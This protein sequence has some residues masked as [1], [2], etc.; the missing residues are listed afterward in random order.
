M[1]MLLTGDP[2]TAQRAY[3]IGMVNEVVPGDRLIAA[4]QALAEGIAANAPLSVRAAKAMVSLT[5]EL[6]L[7]TAYAEAERMW[8][9]VYLSEDAQEGPRAFLREAHTDLEG[10]L[11]TADLPALVA[12]LSAETDDLLR[13]LAYLDDNDNLDDHDKAWLT[14]T[15]ARGWDIKDQVSHLAYFDETTT[16]SALDPERF[17]VEAAELTGHG[18]DFA[19]YIAALH[20]ERTGRDLL[21]WF[22]QARRSLLQ[23]FSGLDPT[24][25]LPWYSLPMGPASSVTARLME[26]WAH[27][28]DIA[29]ALWVTRAPTERLRH[30]AHL[31]VSTIGWSFVVGGLEPPSVPVHVALTAPGGG[32]WTWGPPDATERIEGPALDFCLLVTQRRHRSELAVTATG[33]TANRY[34]G[35]AQVYAGPPGPGRQ[36]VH[37]ATT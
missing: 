12:D 26:T 20:H 2:I 35:L 17:K 23:T 27:G 19:D 30:I 5:A 21:A 13:L 34:L 16:L 18:D 4:T 28:Q 24:V 15:P 3:E 31:G 14:P 22:T 1:Q 9:P 10:M 6:P 7:A 32:S 36:P 37:E 11:M 8:E 29:D 33:G 25:K